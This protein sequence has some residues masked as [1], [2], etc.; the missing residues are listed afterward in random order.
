MDKIKEKLDI[1]K[2]V[3]SVIYL[4]KMEK[5]YD[6]GELDT[7]ELNSFESN[8]IITL[9][10]EEYSLFIHNLRRFKDSQLLV[11]R[12]DYQYKLHTVMELLKNRIL[13]NH[14]KPNK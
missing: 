2:F 8:S 11:L 12:W 13:N 3:D 10:D 5:L 1:K 7:S 4:N 9:S 6:D 14:I